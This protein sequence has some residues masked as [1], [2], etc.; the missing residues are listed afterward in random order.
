[1]VGRL[2]AVYSH[3][4]YLENCGAGKC[5]RMKVKRGVGYGASTC[6]MAGKSVKYT[7]PG[8]SAAT[9]LRA[10]AVT[11]MHVMNA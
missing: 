3:L 7:S 6:L 9:T 8:T 10:G 1:L 11:V 2:K 5:G 4:P